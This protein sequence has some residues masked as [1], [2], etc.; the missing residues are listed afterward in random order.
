MERLESHCWWACKMCSCCGNSTVIP[1]RI[2]NR[3]P[4]RSHVLER[5]W[6]VS[7]ALNT[8]LQH[9]FTPDTRYVGKPTQ[10]AI[11]QHSSVLH[12]IQLFA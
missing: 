12:L 3:A 11:L 6:R 5:L 1:Q 4:I 8:L 10:Q 7:S 2:K 9:D